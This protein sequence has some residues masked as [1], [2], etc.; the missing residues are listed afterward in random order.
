MSAT[1]QGVSA[2]LKMIDLDPGA[3]KEGRTKNCPTCGARV[4]SIFDHVDGCPKPKK[5][6]K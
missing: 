4:A 5:G 1:E 2:R 6:K 3:T